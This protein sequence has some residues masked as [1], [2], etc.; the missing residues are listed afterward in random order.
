MCITPHKVCFVVPQITEE[1]I[2]C[3]CA[4]PEM[5]VFIYFAYLPHDKER[6]IHH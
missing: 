2:Q 4:Q 6:L 5:E 1:S 3:M